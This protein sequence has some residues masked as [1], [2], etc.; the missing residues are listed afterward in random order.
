MYSYGR[1]TEITREEIKF[2]KFIK[3]LR[4]RFNTLFLELLEKQL[5]SKNIASPEDWKEIKPLLKFEYNQDTL[6]A[7]LKENEILAER[8]NRLAEITNYIGR[9][10]S[11]TWV[12]KNV[13]R[14]TDEEIEHMDQEIA[15]EMQ[16]PQF[17][18]NLTDPNLVVDNSPPP[19]SQQ[20]Q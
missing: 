11:N 8:M 17:N 12:R 18:P 19:L 5:L 9:F 7:E 13:L 1:S 16:I 10:Y 6:W 3:R 20:Q 2:N 14:Q 4:A 15:F